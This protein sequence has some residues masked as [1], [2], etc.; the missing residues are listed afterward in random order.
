MSERQDRVEQ[1][2]PV[3]S[4]VGSELNEAV[5]VARPVGDVLNGRRSY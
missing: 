5:S 3:P 2:E 1:Q 4:T